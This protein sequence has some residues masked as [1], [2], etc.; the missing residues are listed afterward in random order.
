MPVFRVLRLIHLLETP[1]NGKQKIDTMEAERQTSETCH[2]RVG[3]KRPLRRALGF[4]LLGCVLG[5]AV[6]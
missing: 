3:A 6:A 5:E 2:A 4:A 1:G